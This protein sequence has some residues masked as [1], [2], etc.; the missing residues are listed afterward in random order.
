MPTPPTSTSAL[1]SP[2]PPPA[3][4][5]L[6]RNSDS[7]TPSDP[8][9]ISYPASTNLVL[10]NIVPTDPLL[11]P[12]LPI[13]RSNLSP[14]CL[15]S[16]HSITVITVPSASPGPISA[17]DDDNLKFSSRKGKHSFESPS[18]DWAKHANTIAAELDFPPQLPLVTDPGVAITGRSLRESNS[19]RTGDRPL[20][21]LHCPYDMV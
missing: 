21:P 10:A 2:T 3:A 12:H 15:E 19:E 6:Q 9:N 17:E 5:S 4:I 11:S 18:V 7:L 8:P 1:L 16:H 14:P 20:H 13:A